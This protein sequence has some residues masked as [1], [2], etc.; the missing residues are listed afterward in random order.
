MSEFVENYYKKSSFNRNRVN[1]V[2]ES[3]QKQ[4]SK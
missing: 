3:A 4:T 2:S 1:A